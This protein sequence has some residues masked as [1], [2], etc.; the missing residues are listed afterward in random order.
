MDGCSTSDSDA[1]FFGAGTV[2]RD[3]FIGEG[4]YV[5]CYE[6]EEIEK[7]QHGFSKNSLLEATGSCTSM[8]MAHLPPS[9]LALKIS[10][11]I[12]L[13]GDYTNGVH[14]FGPSAAIFVSAGM[15]TGGLSARQEAISYGQAILEPLTEL[16][17]RIQMCVPQ[18]IQPT[19]SLLCK[20]KVCGEEKAI[21]DQNETPDITKI[22]SPKWHPLHSY[23]LECKAKILPAD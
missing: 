9:I 13:G 7:K 4:G 3:I 10:F 12:L 2:Y 23:A 11:A 21:L 17:G 15:E 6:M 5:I 18:D 1:F 20:W 19:R 8:E 14:G 22:L 16:R